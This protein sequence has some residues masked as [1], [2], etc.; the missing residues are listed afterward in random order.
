MYF[1]KSNFK[2]HKVLSVVLAVLILMYTIPNISVVQVQA[3]SISDLQQKVA[4]LEKQQKEIE[5]QISALEGDVSAEEDKYNEYLA[6]MENVAKQ[7]SLYQEQIDALNQQ[8]AQKDQEI[9]QKNEEIAAKD[10]EIIAKQAEIEQS[11]EKF[12][13]RLAA[14]YISSSTDSTLGLL[15]GAESFSDFLTQAEVLKNISQ[16][17]NEMMDEML[18]QKEELQNL[19]SELE[20]AK[21]A[22]EAT[23]AE[24]ETKKQ[25]IVTVQQQE[26]EKSNE[27]SAL[28][29][30]SARVLNQLQSKQD[31]LEANE[32]ELDAAREKAIAA[33]I[34]K[35]E[36]ER[37]EN[38]NNNNN[39][40]NNP[41][42]GSEGGQGGGEIIPPDTNGWLW[43]VP[44]YAFVSQWYSSS[45]R[46]IDIAA[47]E[48]SPILAVRSGRVV[49][50]G[51]GNAS[52]GFNRYGNVVLISHGDGYYSLYAHC[53]FLNVST[54][55]TVTQGQQIGGVGN[56]GQSFGNHLHFEIRDGVQGTR[57]NPVNFVTAPH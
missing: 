18:R 56:T 7:I 29:N 28:K 17:D 46:A 35:E 48:G 27:L 6:G 24:I 19:K 26:K 38:E 43:P 8:I 16:R 30:E 51:F 55:Q 9:Q 21:A 22:I 34:A 4:E 45:H 36:E 14:M 50:A 54:G 25:N 12:K 1:L 47:S 49:F 23:R 52:N 32:A 15:L 5:A 3:E 44:I 20:Q 39:N 41:G 57:L 13:D 33:I 40:N 31:S 37:L 2:I 53:H 42:G 10:Q 11:E